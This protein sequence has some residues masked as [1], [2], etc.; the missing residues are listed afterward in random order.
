MGAA[1]KR[2]TP[3]VERVE[4]SLIIW[5]DGSAN[6]LQESIDAQH[7]LR[8]VT[9]N[10]VVFEREDACE[11]YIWL[12]KE[13]ERAILIV[14]GKLGQA[15]VPKVEKNGKLVSIYVYCGDISRNQWTRDHP[16]V[17]IYS[18]F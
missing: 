17:R 5:L 6:T 8:F 14:S 9:G 16:K 15:F 7:Q 4:A 18:S 1:Q 3:T 12:L 2:L 10:L 13:S 11:N